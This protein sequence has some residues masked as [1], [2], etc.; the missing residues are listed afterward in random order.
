MVGVVVAIFGVRS[1]SYLHLLAV[2]G[3]VLTALGGV[4]R[5]SSFLDLGWCE[6]TVDDGGGDEERSVT[7]DD[8][9]ALTRDVARVECVASESHPRHS[10]VDLR[11]LLSG[12]VMILVYPHLHTPPSIQTDSGE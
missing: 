9:D 6:R 2:N 11:Y 5:L 4:S 10:V 3:Q 8:S 7:C 12:S 1:R